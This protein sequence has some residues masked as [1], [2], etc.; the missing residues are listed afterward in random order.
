[1]SEHQDKITNEKP[2]K[3]PLSFEKALE[4]LLATKPEDI[5]QAEKKE[6]QEKKGNK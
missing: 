2:V 3:I 4:A 6:K 1:M 5:K